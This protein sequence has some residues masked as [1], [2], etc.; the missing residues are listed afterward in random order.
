[1]NRAKQGSLF[2]DS[3]P[4]ASSLNLAEGSRLA[5]PV[6]EQRLMIRASAGTG[7]TFQLA[8]RFVSLLRTSPPDRILASTFTRKAAGEI[9]DRILLRLAKAV[10]SEDDFHSLQEFAGAPKLDREECSRLLTSLTSH[11][12][13]LRVGTLDGFFSRLATCFSL[14]LQLPPNWRMIDDLEAA[15]LREEAIN[16]VLHAGEVQELRTLVTQIASGNPGR[17]VHSV[18][19]DAIGDFYGIYC[20][21]TGE[22][23]RPF[24]DLKPPSQ[25]EWDAAAECL[26]TTPLSDKRMEKARIG[27]LERMENQDWAGMLKGGLLMKAV[28]NET[29]YR[30]ELP[31]NIKQAYLDIFALVRRH[32]LFVWGRKTEATYRL[33]EKFDAEYRRLKRQRGGLEFN[34]V[35]RCL[36][37][38]L[39][40]KATSDL[41]HRLDGRIDHLLLDEF[42]DTSPDQWNVLYPFARDAVGADGKSFF[43]VG[44][45]KQAIY[46]WRGGE[47]AIFDTLASQLSGLIQK[48]LNKSFRSSPVVID[49]VNQIFRGMIAHDNFDR[50]KNTIQNWSGAFPEHETARTELPGHFCLRTSPDKNEDGENLRSQLFEHVAHLAK[51]TLEKH[52]QGTIGI[53]TRKN[54]AIGQIIFELNRLGV[55]ASEEGGNPLTDSAAV[56]LLLSLFQLADHPG[57]TIALFHVANSPLGQILNLSFDDSEEDVHRFAERLREKL[58][59]RGYGDFISSLVPKLA[60]HCSRRELRRLIQMTSLAD[61]FDTL[62][63]TLRPSEFVEF[64]ENQKV[65]EPTDARVRVMSIHQ[66]KGLQFDTV[67][68]AEADGLWSTPAP[69]FYSLRSHPT[70]PAEVVVTARRLDDQPLFPSAVRRAYEQTIERDVTGQLCLLYV[71]LTRAIHNLQVVVQ[72]CKPSSKESSLPK[73][74]A[75][76]LRAALAPGKRRTAETILY[77]S[78]DPNWFASLVSKDEEPEEKPEPETLTKVE[79]AKKPTVRNLARVTPSQTKKSLRVPMKTVLPTTKSGARERGTLIHSW[80]EQLTWMERQPPEEVLKNSSIAY[81]FSPKELE[82]VYAGFLKM[83]KRKEVKQLLSEEEYRNSAP[84]L[85]PEKLRDAIRNE[86]LVIEVR[87]ERK[88]AVPDRNGLLVGSF[89][90]LVT[91]RVNGQV[92]AADIIDFKTDGIGND[93]IEFEDRMQVYRPQLRSYR[94]AV[95]KLYGIPQECIAARIVLLAAGRVIPVDP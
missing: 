83:L 45:A 57:H 41:T 51:E 69:K 59:Q 61:Q 16:S 79:F 6:E 82:G 80:M 49:A 77:E 71:A 21:S 56:Q 4:N 55:D 18:I 37:Q 30:K 86:D 73:T 15:Q 33:I 68:F 85:F 64:I 32:E 27:D 1:M 7:K 48:P 88:F 34:D 44:D 36:A 12:H 65:K 72:P 38:S 43:C 13:R 5:I 76:I 29:Y 54:D 11:L 19:L 42:Q 91:F 26:R 93:V 10:I 58:V 9:L 22:A 60:Q 31:E 81:S 52:P 89:D 25:E 50:E 28:N 70:E 90:R 17:S 3:T 94:R 39:G 23:W 53:L 8:N 62:P 40:E 74:F 46:G 24:G 84:S 95:E 75:G 66:S 47:A 35:T 78:G 20:D 14:E 67:I 87:N 92:V 2:S 63:H